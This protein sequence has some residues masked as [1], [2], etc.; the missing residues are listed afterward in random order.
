MAEVVRELHDLVFDRGAI[1]RAD[2]ADQI[3]SVKRRTMEVRANE[4]VGALV[5]LGHVT[6]QLRTREPRLAAIR[7]EQRACGWAAAEP[8]RPGRSSSCRFEAGFP[9]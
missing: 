8:S 3:E 1:A 4:R 7:K 5:G 6:R 9:F 2:T